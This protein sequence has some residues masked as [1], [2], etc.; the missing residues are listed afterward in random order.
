M[1]PWEGLA[2]PWLSGFRS[3]LVAVLCLG[4]PKLHFSGCSHT[5]RSLGKQHSQGRGKGKKQAKRRGVKKKREIKRSEKEMGG[6]KVGEMEGEKR[7]GI[8]G[9]RR[10]IPV[11]VN[12]VQAW[13]RVTGYFLK[14][15]NR[16]GCLDNECDPGKSTFL[17]GKAPAFLSPLLVVRSCNTVSRCQAATEQNGQE[18]MK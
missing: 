14:I 4:K 3:C 10:K 5:L 17:L 12:N 15:N 6:E 1:I 7:G 9:T 2:Q 18:M 16:A 11:E 8:K 13:G